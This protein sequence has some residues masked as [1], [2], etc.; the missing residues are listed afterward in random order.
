[1]PRNLDRFQDRC[2]GAPCGLRSAWARL[3]APIG[4]HPGSGKEVHGDCRS[5]VG[6]QFLIP[7]IGHPRIPFDFPTP[8][9]HPLLDHSLCLRRC[10]RIHEHTTDTYALAGLVHKEL[11]IRMSKIERLGLRK[12]EVQ[13]KC[14]HGWSSH[15]VDFLGVPLADF[16]RYADF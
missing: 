11:N 9:D 10:S 2:S 4:L 16:I 15:T 13:L 8:L 3:L 1:M 7:S 14:V 6:L 5:Q 12:Y